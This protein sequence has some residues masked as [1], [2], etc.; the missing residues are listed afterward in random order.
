MFLG[1]SPG[2]PVIK[3]RISLEELWEKIL[4]GYEG[5]IENFTTEH[6]ALGG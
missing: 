4:L 1:E 5:C 2:G 6:F 3:A